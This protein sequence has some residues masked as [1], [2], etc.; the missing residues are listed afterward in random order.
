[1]AETPEEQARMD[2]ARER[3]QRRLAKKGNQP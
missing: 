3:Q 1:M 2:A